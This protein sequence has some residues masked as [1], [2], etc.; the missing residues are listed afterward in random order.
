MDHAHSETRQISAA[1]LSGISASADGDGGISI[2]QVSD[3]TLLTNQIEPLR[4]KGVTHFF[5][6]IETVSGALVALADNFQK[7]GVLLDF[8]RSPQELIAKLDGHTLLFIQSEGVLTDAAVLSELLAT[9]KPVLVTLDGRDENAKFE[10]IDLNTRWTGLAIIDRQ[11]IAA[12]AAL[13]IGYSI[14]S[15]L[16]RQALQEK[17]ATKA[18]KQ[19]VIQNGLLHKIS[20]EADY[21]AYSSLL[22]ARRASGIN[23]FLESRIGGPLGKWLAPHIW[24]SRYGQ[25]ILDGVTLGAALV[26]FATGYAGFGIA[27]T[28]FALFAIFGITLSNV[29]QAADS[30]NIKMATVAPATWVVLFGALGM[31]L[32]QEHASIFDNLFPFLILSGLLFLALL[33]RAP[34]WQFFILPSPAFAAVALLVFAVIGDILIGA[35]LLA[36][37]LLALL[38]AAR[39]KPDNLG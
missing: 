4:A 35:K 6:E 10:R 30:D 25:K 23:G 15:S 32:W 7:K 39:I 28:A 1:L 36:L 18:M 2:G 5:I 20:D 13:P 9:A 22:L 3:V 37:L 27:A 11:T 19:D 16:L 21:H 12:I 8:V 33:T 17:I 14:A 29:V 34:A 26:S 38:I 24:Q 31:M